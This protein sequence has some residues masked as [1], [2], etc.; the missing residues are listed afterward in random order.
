MNC[1]SITYRRNMLVVLAAVCLLASAAYSAPIRLTNGEP[2]TGLSG[3]LGSQA[4]YS[5]EVPSG[6]DELVIA[7]SGGTG[8]CDL[9]VRKDAAPTLTN[10]DYRPYVLGNDE[11]V[12]IESPEAGTWHI[13]LNGYTAY[14]KLTL[15]ATY[16]GRSTLITPLESDVPVEDL[17]GDKGSELYYSF[18]VSEGMSE[19]EIAI[20]GG[21]GDCD[22]YVKH[23]ALPTTSDYDYRPFRLGNEET[24]TVENPTAGTWYVMLRGY[25]GYS[26]VTL[27]ASYG[28]GVGT[29]LENGVPV[30]SLSGDVGDEMLFRIELPADQNNL[31]VTI[32]GGTGDCDLYVQHETPPTE[33]E[34]DFRPFLAGNEETVSVPSPAEGVWY[35][36]LRGYSAY[37]EVTLIATYGELIALEDEVPVTGLSDES[38]GKQFFKVSIPTGKNY[39][40]ISISG[41]SGECDL[42][43]KQGARPTL[44]DYDY[45]PYL[46]GNN[47]SVTIFNEN[48]EPSTWYIM[49]VAR[50]AYRGVTLEADY[51]FTGT[52]KLLTNEVPVTG[53]DGGKDSERYY[54][55]I[56]PSNQRRL[57]FNIYGGTGDADLY[58]QQDG[59]PSITQ[60]DY[61]PYLLGNNETVSIDEP[62]EGNWLIMIRGYDDYEDLTLVAS[63]E[64]ESGGHDDV[65][66]LAS[67]SPVKGIDGAKNSEQVFRIDVPKGQEQLEIAI[68][69]GSGDCDL[70]VR[71]GEVPTTTTWDYRPFVLGNEETVTIEAPDEAAYYIML[72]G[73]AAYEDVTLT[74]TYW[75]AEDPIEELTSGVPVTDLSATAGDETL[76]RIDVPEGQDSLTIQITGGTGDCDMYVKQGEEPTQSSWDYRPYVL[77]N[78]ETV[79]IEKPAEGT[80]YIMLH[81]YQD[82]S[83][84]TLMATHG[85]VVEGNNFTTD[86]NCVAVWN[87]EPGAL[88]ADSI[89]TN[90]LSTD[91]SVIESNTVDFVQGDGAGQWMVSN[92]PTMFIADDDLDADFPLKRNGMNRNISVCFWVKFDDLSQSKHVL[93]AKFGDTR[94]QRSLMIYAA[95]VAGRYHL[96][97]AKGYFWGTGQE[98]VTEGNVGLETDRWYHVAVTWN[99]T[100]KTANLTLWD[101]SVL[102]EY[103]ES[104]VMTYTIS[105]TD[106]HVELGT[107]D[108]TDGTPDG[109]SALRGTLDEVAV[110]NDVLT[111]NEIELIRQ[112]TYGGK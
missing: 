10:Y 53:I 72:R 30:E 73:Y 56:V 62:N 26:G 45:R 8:D 64:G 63:Y 60:Y 98:T 68:T 35:V 76:Y 46:S 41:G 51:W 7:I 107:Y 99:N 54:R 29:L 50:K 38:E 80:Y 102:T 91:G 61:R 104:A 97:V 18:E 2:E 67:G 43:V 24:V 75:T 23:G 112:G 94:S 111:D 13:M 93:W 109:P 49:L 9:Y 27:L 96:R 59:V 83:G 4:F 66:V 82:Y 17:T 20:T 106:A 89:G 105:V 14:G 12:T 47:E 90:T 19:I 70:Y 39:L 100:S 65:T 84:L 77:G 16:T 22:L 110:F 86:Q 69:G 42:Y 74:A 79:E 37:T 6:Q 103:T 95:R 52:V 101:D 87:L 58:V 108:G 28:G 48:R 81:A 71:Q 25:S 36:M 78:E 32:A 31:T 85:A 40:E 1:P 55:F 5:I 33:S 57:E 21:T 92:K 11:T 3:A 34:Y 15:V 88:T 44:T